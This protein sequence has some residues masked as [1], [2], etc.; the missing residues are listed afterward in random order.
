MNGPTLA[1]CG[2]EAKMGNVGRAASP[3]AQVRR[4]P[5]ML[6]AALGVTRAYALGATRL[7]RRVL[8]DVVKKTDIAIFYNIFVE[9]PLCAGGKSGR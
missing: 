9:I 7:E 8:G 3:R 1:F 2:A 4:R 5:A 6:W